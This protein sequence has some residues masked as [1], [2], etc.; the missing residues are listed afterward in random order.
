MINVKAKSQGCSFL[1]YP[2]LFTFDETSP[3]SKKHPGWSFLPFS[4]RLT[5]RGLCWPPGRCWD[6][7]QLSPSP[8][9]PSWA[10]SQSD[11]PSDSTSLSSFWI[12]L[13]YLI[14]ISKPF[15]EERW[16]GCCCLQVMRGD[17]GE[18]V[19]IRRQSHCREHTDRDQSCGLASPITSA[20]FPQLPC[21]D[22]R[23][24]PL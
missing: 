1:M 4:V 22:D 14:R 2:F 3:V 12:H 21:L 7:S 23:C 17:M 18:E 16:G 8:R 5:Q 9:T 13:H 6:T 24:C 15:R 11:E 10:A 19:R 20:S